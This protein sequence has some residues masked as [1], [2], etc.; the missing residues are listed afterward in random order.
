[1]SSKIGMFVEN[2]FYEIY[3]ALDVKPKTIEPLERKGIYA[4]GN[5]G[6]HF[7]DHEL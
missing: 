2:I 1:M 4:I 7:R 3:A 6:R 5:E